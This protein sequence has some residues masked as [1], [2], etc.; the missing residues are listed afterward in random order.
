VVISPHIL[1]GRFDDRT[2][3]RVR[4]VSLPVPHLP[5]EMAGIRLAF[6][7]DLHL[8]RLVKP[9]FVRKALRLGA[10]LK[11]Q[12][13][14]LGGDIVGRPDHHALALPELLAQLPREQ[15][16]YAVMGN[17][18]YYRGD[19]DIARLLHQCGVRLLVNEHVLIGPDGREADNGPRM[20]L[21]GLDDCGPGRPDYASALR[22]IEPGVCTLLL[23]H[24]PDLA[25]LSDARGDLM[26]SGHTH[27]GQVRLGSFI[28]ARRTINRNYVDGLVQ[29]P[30]FPIFIS[31]GLGIAGVALRLC[32][33]P[34]LWDITLRPRDHAV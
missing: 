28:P 10:E 17:H 18:E 33:P 23:G 32:C 1:I 2:P 5:A 29:G 9:S 15:A 26:L 6:L 19:Q 20:A 21:V 34:E 22:G 7:P 8:G 14:V 25:D 24:N 30:H 11:A 27:G 4:R 16:V 12:V 31:R 3:I 13:M